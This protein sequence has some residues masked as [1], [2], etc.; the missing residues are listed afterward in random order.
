MSILMTS[1]GIHSPVNSLNRITSLSV[2]Y[3]LRLKEI[4]CVA[5]ERYKERR[6]VKVLFPCFAVRLCSCYNYICFLV[7]PCCSTAVFINLLHGIP[8]PRI[9]ISLGSFSCNTLLISNC[10]KT[11]IYSVTVW[12]P[13]WRKQERRRGVKSVLHVRDRSENSRRLDLKLC[14]L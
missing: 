11:S 12:I 5:P 9:Q 2:C 1:W 4:P 14:G 6:L 13:L 7:E 3:L 8:D 10:L